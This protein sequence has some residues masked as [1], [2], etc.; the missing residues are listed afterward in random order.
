MA[1]DIKFN[2]RLN[3][4]G[5]NV[6]VQASQSVKELQRNLMAAKTSGQRLSE[7]LIKF[8]Q[9]SQVYTN[10]SGALST[11][12]GVMNGYIA[13]AN[14]ATEAQ[15]K[16]TTIMRQRMGATEADTAAV[17]DAVAAQTK[18]GIVGGTV[19]R[20]G[21]QQL[22]TFSSQRQTL[23]TLLP[24]M[25]N[26]L[27]QQKGLNATSE[28]AVGVANLMGKAL[29]GNVGALTR[30]GI[31][32]TDQQKEL[33]KTGDEYTR[34]KT[35]AQA[36][37]DNVG[38]MNAELAKTDAGQVK[39]A[40]MAFASLQ[41]TIGKAI[42]PCQGLINL[43]AQTG[44]AV[45]GIGQLLS[46]I[47]GLVAATGIASAASSLWHARTV[48][49]TAATNLFAAAMNGAS[50][51]ATTLKFALRG[52][53]SATVIGAAVTLLGVGLEK[54]INY[55]TAGSNASGQFKQAVGNTTKTL[56]QQRDEALAPVLAKYQ[57]LQ[58]K[59]KSLKSVHEKNEFLKANKTAFEQLGVSID[60]VG[61]AESFFVKNTKAVEAAMYARAEAAAAASLAE[62]EMRK[63]L[64]AESRVKS[65]REKDKANYKRQNHTG[66]T[67]QDAAIDALVDSG[68][69]K[70]TSK[71]TQRDVA[72]LGKHRAAARSYSNRGASAAAR[73]TAGLRPY[74]N[75][76]AGSTTGTGGARSTGG[77]A[78]KKALMGSLDWY[79]QKM[80]ELRKR[81]YA[82]NDEATAAGLQAQYEDLEQKSKNLKVA[83]GLEE[84]KAAEV[85][86]YAEQ[87]QD[88]LK[89]A[90][91]GMDNATTVEARVKASA[92]VAEIQKEI[93]IATRGE[94]SIEADVE[95][96]YVMKGSVEDKRQSYQNA[97]S[98]VSRIQQDYEIGIIGKEDA[99]RQVAEVN[100]ALSQMGSTLK[101]LK[102]EV[103]ASSLDKARESMAGLAQQFGGSG[104]QIG[105]Q[106]MEIAKA[107]KAVR[108]AAKQTNKET[109]A[110]G[111]GFSMTSSYATAGAAGLTAI[112]NALQQVGSKSA[113]A[114]AGAVMAAIGQIVL[115]FATYTAQSAQL[116]PWGWIA[117]VAGG[118]AA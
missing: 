65:D 14:S 47:R 64:E 94:L 110:T 53:M 108:Q 52:L 96:A 78:D 18:L 101:P 7:T 24:A 75:G 106:I 34:A 33:I 48:L 60:S 87:L 3:I 63:A 5:K 79:D 2:I 49:S 31:T 56:S 6:V 29:M 76:N 58:T 11:L 67:G 69:I 62:E 95:P 39:K 118:L 27:A 44:F 86:S 66:K 112:G 98:K 30:V 35:L 109:T 12:S 83:I 32:L 61:T 37:T 84:P 9:V 74:Q 45:S 1:K 13:K 105:S 26:L 92:K 8:N 89:E 43:F 88:R 102:I 114:K 113:A 72:E 59:W 40:Q 85:K 38:N 51:G 22:A 111:K 80:Q 36:I 90:Q 17:N 20:S 103:E 41:T 54:L 28:D 10:V 19:Q 21:L 42:A 23:E 81:I 68:A 73:A 4:D 107:M 117:A 70:V 77:A 25:N 99:E 93:D 16:L 82:T 91:K 116:G 15:T 55:F 71:R 115:G 104:A 46:A 57:E 97:Q 50:V 100:A